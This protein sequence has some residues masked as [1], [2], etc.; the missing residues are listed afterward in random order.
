MSIREKITDYSRGDNL[1]L[2]WRLFYTRGRVKNA[3]VKGILTFW[4]SR[5]A[6]KH[7]GYVGAGAEINEIP[8]LPHG[9]HGIY[10]SRYSSI[11]AGCRIYQNVTIGEIEQRAPQIGRNCLI[12]AGA[13]II[14]DIT[15]GDSVKIGAGAVVF[16]DIQDNSTVVSHPPRI[17]T[18]EVKERSAC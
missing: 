13:V 18:K 12:G 2:F 1:R 3:L 7:G 17:L 15:I 9:L 16:T 6:H 8:S 14:G 10:I 5:L 11:G 4:C